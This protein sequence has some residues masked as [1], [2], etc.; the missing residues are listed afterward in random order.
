MFVLQVCPSYPSAVVVPKNI[1]DSDLV[2][3]ANFRQASRFP[4]LA[5]RHEGSVSKFCVVM[6]SASV[7]FFKLFLKIQFLVCIVIYIA[8]QV[9]IAFDCHHTFLLFIHSSS[10]CPAYSHDLP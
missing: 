3:I 10:L 2:A 1:E 9:S 7:V 4:V 6:K 5:Y 8:L